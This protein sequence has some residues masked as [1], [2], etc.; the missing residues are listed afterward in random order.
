M[1]EKKSPSLRGAGWMPSG[2][3]D[4][5]YNYTGT[6]RIRSAG[7]SNTPTLAKEEKPLGPRRGR[8]GRT[9]PKPLTREKSYGES[10]RQTEGKGDIKDLYTVKRGRPGSAPDLRGKGPLSTDHKKIKA[11]WPVP[12]KEEERGI[13]GVRERGYVGGGGEKS[14]SGFPA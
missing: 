3:S 12:K 11:S 10:Y 6:V 14:Q 5:P 9:L 8:F 13:G 4:L 2:G 7:V 1:P